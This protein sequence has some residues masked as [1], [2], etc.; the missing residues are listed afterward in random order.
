VNRKTVYD[1]G[2]HKGEDTAYYLHRGYRV[3]AIEADP[4]LFLFCKEKFREF[5]E[6]GALTIIHGA[7]IDDDTQKSIKFYKNIKESVWGTAVKT[8]ADRN[9]MFGAESVEIEVPVV[10]FN[11]LLNTYGCPYYLK[12]DIEGM[13]I[14][15]L[16]KLLLCDCRPKFVSIESE[17][18][19]FAALIEEFNIFRSLGYEKFFIKQQHN[20]N[21]DSVPLNSLEGDYINYK[22]L[23]GS[24]GLFG[25]DLGSNW[26]S[27]ED[28][29]QTYK[30]IFRDYKYFGDTSVLTKYRLG[31]HIRRILQTIFRRPLPGWYDTHASM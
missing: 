5:I 30:N 14:V 29:I 24:T 15:C 23:R 21:F 16:K 25:T 4:D 22:F 6:I 27:R 18:V 28:A 3:V 10:N 17:K 12:I 26:L 1:V 19:D 20:I 11:E 13:D 31:K 9:A 7:V 2:L 8:W